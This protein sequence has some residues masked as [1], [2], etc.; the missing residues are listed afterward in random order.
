VWNNLALVYERSGAPR[1][2]QAETWQRVLQ[3][4][5]AQGSGLHVERATRHLAALGVT[6]GP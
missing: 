3:L 2:L 5:R 1:E 6:M 4:A